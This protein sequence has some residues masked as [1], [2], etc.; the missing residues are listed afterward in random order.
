MTQVLFSF[1][2]EDYTNPGAD[3]A[4]LRLARTL[5]AE[6]VRGCFNIVGEL[7][8]ALEE[9]NRPDIIRALE[10]HEIDFH[11]W[12]H[13]WHPTVVEYGDCADWNVG[14]ERF[15][16]EER[17][18]SQAVK[19]IFKRDKL[20]AAIPPGNCITSQAPY[21]YHDL[22]IP[23]YSGSLFKQTRGKTI[24]YC[25][26]INLENNLYLD[27]VLW[28][29]GKEAFLKRADAYQDYERVIVC[30]HPNMSMYKK[31]WDALNC[32]GENQVEFG[33]W[34]LP[35]RHS[36]ED[37]NRFYEGFAEIV[38]YF[39]TTPGYELVTYEDIWKE[40]RDRR[41]PLSRNRLISA[42]RKAK[43]RFFFVEEGGETFSLA[44]LYE[45]CIHFA[46]G[47]QGDFTPRGKRGPLEQPFAISYPVTLRAEDIRREAENCRV[48]DGVPSSL[49][50][51]GTQIGPADFMWAVLQMLE[52]REQISLSP[53]DCTIPT[54]NYYNFEKFALKHTW[55]HSETFEDNFTTE[56]IRLQAWTIRE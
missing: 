13:T 25:N 14:Y 51:G 8:I 18:A 15:L 47:G 4:I 46:S 32:Q 5:T 1:D 31:F 9:R 10:A 30:M 27:D 48:F 6:G 3:E 44:E 39:K 40:E 22:D 12:R 33:H 55:M 16:N 37:I 43:E 56:R 49:N 28:N 23:L 42:L 24:W 38:R 41:H 11:S 52:G 54:Q 21:V 17:R 19:R 26:Q 34:R 53:F 36:E 35:E 45:A 50:I 2:T 29:E 20:F 7:G